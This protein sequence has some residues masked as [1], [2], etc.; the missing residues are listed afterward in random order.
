MFG[1]E[2]PAFSNRARHVLIRVLVDSNACAAPRFPRAKARTF[3]GAMIGNPALLFASAK[4]A[5]GGS[6]KALASFRPCG[7]KSVAGE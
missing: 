5:A 4:S 2:R 1:A 3:Y 6:L 7:L